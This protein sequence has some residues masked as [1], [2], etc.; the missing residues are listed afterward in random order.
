[1]SEQA[2]DTTKVE[3]AK[4]QTPAVDQLALIK[5]KADTMGITYSAE[6]TVDSIRAR[7]NAKL[8][9]TETKKAPEPEA[10]K[11]KHQLRQEAILDATRLI[12][13]RIT[14]M[15]PRKSDLPG[16]YFTV[17]NG[18]IGH[19]TRFIPY[20]ET[21]DGWHIENMLLQHLKERM[22]Y[23]LRPKKTANGGSLPDGK[24]VKEFAIEELAPLTQ[25]ELRILANKQAAAAGNAV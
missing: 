20:G 7:I 16:E 22:F 5:T 2:K 3:P 10:E 9:S 18:V 23:Q 8:E 13:V 11:S 21:E 15:D 19:I 12:R 1:M 14:N 4:A 25:E 24:W 17:S 6:D